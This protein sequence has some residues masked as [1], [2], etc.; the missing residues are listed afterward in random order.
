MVS[1]PKLTIAATANPTVGQNRVSP[2]LCFS[3]TANAISNTPA[4]TSVTQ[5]ITQPP[6]PLDPDLP[7]SCA[8]I[9]SE[10]VRSRHVRLV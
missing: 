8:S 3:S 5:A 1:R 6:R 9:C 2:W 10:F 4:P 7:P